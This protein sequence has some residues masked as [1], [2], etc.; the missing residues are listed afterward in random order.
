MADVYEA[1]HLHF[2]LRVAVKILRDPHGRAWAERRF[3][4]EARIAARLSTVHAVRIFDVGK[5]GDGA[6]YLVLEL[7]QG[8]TLAERIARPEPIPIPD[9]A[10]IVA[11]AAEALA[12]MHSIQMVHR[13]VKPSNLFLVSDGER[14]RV[15]LLDFGVA[16]WDGTGEGPRLTGSDIQI[17]TP[18][19]MAPE[20]Y[21]SPQ[22][23]DA[24]TDVWALGVTL[25]QMLT[26]RHPFEGRNTSILAHQVIEREPPPLGTLRPDVP[27]AL[28]A[29]AHRCLAKEP[30]G[31]P[32]NMWALLAE[33]EPF[34]ARSGV[35]SL[36]PPPP[37]SDRG[38]DLAPR[39]EWRAT[40]RQFQSRVRR[41]AV[42]FSAWVPTHM[43]RSIPARVGLGAMSAG[44]AALAFLAA[45]PATEGETP[46]LAPSATAVSASLPLRLVDP[47]PPTIELVDAPRAVVNVRR[48]EATRSDSPR[49]VRSPH[50]SS[51]GRGAPRPVAAPRAPQPRNSDPSGN[52]APDDG[53]E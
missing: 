21:E 6:P 16:S 15:K 49:P 34:R 35:P 26:R 5:W 4:R 39:R 45:T 1:E 44:L 42:P 24:R 28:T 33:L 18:S 7:L 20:Q 50:S 27:A 41:F 31:R 48:E 51:R 11:Q 37:P 12:E 17:G 43:R 2:R 40:L 53:V 19:F 23:V 36:S 46:S 8:E 32:A 25:Y 47:V 30:S 10:E 14:S 29:I 3:M 22:E 38:A 13:D 9:A 52:D